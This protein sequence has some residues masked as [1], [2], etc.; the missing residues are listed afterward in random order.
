MPLDR[1]MLEG[2]H[3]A[4]AW[5]ADVE[6]PC[7]AALTADGNPWLDYPA[8]PSA[9]RAEN[10]GPD[11]WGNAQP[12]M[13]RSRANSF[14][15]FHFLCSKTEPTDN[16]IIA[17]WALLGSS[18]A[19]PLATEDIETESSGAPSARQPEVQTSMA[20]MWALADQKLTSQTTD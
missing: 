18:W 17:T 9:G 11:L 14:W 2:C 19:N 10:T 13:W 6:R 1:I 16:Y 20:I 12:W 8:S 15:I 4:P 7:C 5:C 3:D